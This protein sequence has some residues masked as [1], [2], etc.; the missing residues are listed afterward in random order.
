MFL[1]IFHPI[2][3]LKDIFGKKFMIYILI[4]LNKPWCLISDKN[5]ITRQFEKKGES[6]TN[7][8][9]IQIQ[10]TGLD[11]NGVIT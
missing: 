11:S 7:F 3:D 5:D 4:N 8:G 1:F 10:A 6:V 9:A 2:I